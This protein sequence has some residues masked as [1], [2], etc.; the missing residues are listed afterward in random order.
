MSN[1]TYALMVTGPCP[2]C[3]FAGRINGLSI[4]KPVNQPYH[5]IVCPE[6]KG[7]A[8]KIEIIPLPVSLGDEIADLV[9]GEL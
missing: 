5:T 1:K 2:T 6:C 3:G 7:R 9:R 8:T 4:A